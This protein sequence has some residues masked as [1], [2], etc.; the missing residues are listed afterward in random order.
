MNTKTIL[1]LIILLQALAYCL[2]ACSVRENR[3][4]CP[5][6]LI[7]DFSETEVSETGNAEVNA[8]GREGFLYEA[9][10]PASQY[11]E[12]HVI[13]VPRTGVFLNV[14]YGS[15]SCFSPEKGFA[16]A[17]GR[18]FPPLYL[19]SSYLDTNAET[20]EA[21]VKIHKEHCRINIRMKAVS[22]P[23]PF[24]ILVEGDICGA[25]IDGL[26]L[27]GPFS[28]AP[29]MDDDGA[30][31]V[32]V[33]RQTSSSLT[34]KII[35]ENNVLRVFSIG[36]YIIESGYDWTAESLEDVEVEIDYAKTEVSFSVND[37]EKTVHFDVE[38]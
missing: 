16:V 10:I 13:A 37:W 15:E 6:F 11:G 24:S 3:S 12:R 29:A 4:E 28:Y 7:V 25:G 38:I 19:Y 27:P 31:S 26:P 14:S 9:E 18:N 21:K 34:L 32:I 1:G 5:C 20:V 22:G 17:A 2:T 23:Y 35:D 8:T 33:P 36:E 30:C